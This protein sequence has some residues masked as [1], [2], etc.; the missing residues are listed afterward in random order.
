MIRFGVC[1]G[2]TVWQVSLWYSFQ[3]PCCWYWFSWD[4]CFAFWVII[5]IIH[6]SRFFI[7]FPPLFWLLFVCT[8]LDNEIN[9][10]CH[11]YEFLILLKGQYNFL[12]RG[13]L[14][15]E[16]VNAFRNLQCI[17]DYNFVNYKDGDINEEVTLKSKARRMDS[18]EECM[19]SFVNIRY[20]GG[21][22]ENFIGV[23]LGWLCFVIQNRRNNMD[24]RHVS[25][26]MNV[27]MDLLWY[28]KDRTRNKNI[29]L[30]VHMDVSLDGLVMFMEDLRLQ[31]YWMIGS[32]EQQ[33]IK[34]DQS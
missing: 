2:K 12:W 17:V 7:F 22:R 24:I 26:N 13:S 5:T 4:C 30:E 29:L 27:K 9:F 6:G 16:N 15:I 1:F 34:V 20:L 21:W 10:R 28:S 25:L 33:G 14:L 23:L 19:N 32:T 18:L 31:V 11:Y 8:I 3:L